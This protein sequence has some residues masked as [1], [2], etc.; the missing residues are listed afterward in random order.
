MQ[1]KRII[2]SAG[3]TG[4]HLFPAQ[5]IAERLSKH[6]EVLFVAG[7][8][9]KSPFFDKQTFPYQDIPSATINFSRPLQAVRR[10]M[11][12]C[13]GTFQALQIIRKFRPDLVVG[14]GSFHSLPVLA[15]ATLQR[16]PIVLHEQNILPGRVNKLFSRVAQET[17][18]TFGQSALGLK[19][20][21]QVVAFP[22]RQREKYDP[23]DYFGWKPGKK[24]ILVCGGSQGAKRLNQLAPHLQGYRIIHIVGA[25]GE[26]ENIDRYYRTH[27]I[28]AIVKQFE[29]RLDL[30]MEIAD[31][32]I[33]RAGA[34]TICELIKYATPAIL[35]PYPQAR[36]DHQWH[37]AHF[38]A[39]KVGGG[40]VIREED[41]DD[42]A[43][44]L[45]ISR[46][47]LKS[48]RSKLLAF[49]KEQ[50]TNGLESLILEYL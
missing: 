20:K 5:A 9:E 37:N 23:W 29:P 2:L 19:G 3:G 22:M 27:Q 39:E 17:A 28:P 35:I 36:D 42:K 43:L 25:N 10:G 40:V 7:H 4:G 31:L 44:Y 8:L 49:Q 38:F 26:I 34:A 32:A 13:S 33:C 50:A 45:A 47:D 46:L 1:K 11:T 16:V 30:A 14:F 18:I 12:L 6:A 24:T 15:A 21:T 48:C 41:L